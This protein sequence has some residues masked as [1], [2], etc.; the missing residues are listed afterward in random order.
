MIRN[1][2]RKDTEKG[3]GT[4]LLYLLYAYIQDSKIA[5]RDGTEVSLNSKSETEWNTLNSFQ[6]NT[7]TFAV[8]NFL[9]V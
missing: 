1:D 6:K 5:E 4:I 8:G 9:L 7:F 3:V 2:K